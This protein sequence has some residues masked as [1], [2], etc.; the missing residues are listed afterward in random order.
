MR[1]IVLAVFHQLVTGD[2]SQL[3]TDFEAL[4]GECR[5]HRTLPTTFVTVATLIRPY[6][7]SRPASAQAAA[8]ISVRTECQ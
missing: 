8:T 1:S 6:L 7:M 4:C 5:H 3:L 2:T